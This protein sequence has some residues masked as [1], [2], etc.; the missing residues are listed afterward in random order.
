MRTALLMTLLLTACGTVCDQI[1]SAEDGV[2][3]KEQ[4]CNSGS[5]TKHDASKCNAGLSKCS[6]DDT[7]K[8]NAY[9]GCLNS[10]PNCQSGM[11]LSWSISVA[12]CS[13][14]LSGLSLNCAGAIN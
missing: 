4:S 8:L 3:A 5:F 1:A 10:L 6:P 13:G 12:E 2:S 9:A 14:K 11:E 7:Q